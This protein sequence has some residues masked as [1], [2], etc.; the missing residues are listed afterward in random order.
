LAREL[1]EATKKEPRRFSNLALQIPVTAHNAYIE[2][3]LWGLT[4]TEAPDSE[5]LI[6]V[7]KHAHQHP[8]KPFGSDIARLAERHPRIA[9]DA[10]ILEI[11]I[12]YALN[13]EAKENEE[14]DKVN[15]EREIVSI[16]ILLQKT[17]M[18]IIRGNIGVRGNAWEA[19]G[20]V[21]WEI[22]ETEHKIWD[23]MTIALNKEKLICVRCCMMKPLVPLFNRNKELFSNALQMLITEPV[24]NS[25]QENSLW[26]SPLITN[27]GIDL[28]PYLLYQ[29]P[30]LAD[31]LTTKLLCSED[32]THKLIGAWVIF[33]QSFINHDY[34]EKADALVEISMEHRRLMAS[35]ASEVIASAE[36]RHRAEALLKRFFYDDDEQVRM[37]AAGCFKNI[38]PN[39]VEIFRELI[40]EFLKS[41]AFKK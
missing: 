3:V 4:E 23:A 22:P 38:E 10:E 18:I 15:V 19:L 11:L 1:K 27:T 24:D 25:Y 20:V 36:N 12:W 7:V 14:S 21:L 30:E 28:I 2:A 9:L 40:N 33:Q 29:L 31:T 16:K 6:P 41:P 8:A 13:G 37:Q 5:L 17:R 39:E 34:T 32:V 35:I 26:L